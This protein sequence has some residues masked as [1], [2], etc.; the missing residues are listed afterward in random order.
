MGAS[1]VS[2][3]KEAGRFIDVASPARKNWTMIDASSNQTLI[4]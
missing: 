4:V 2:V 3:H 1:A